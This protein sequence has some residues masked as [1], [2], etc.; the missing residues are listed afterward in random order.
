[1]TE[2]NPRLRL[3]VVGIIVMALFSALFVRLWFLQIASG[4]EAAA[5]ETTQNRVRIVRE[6][7]IRGRIL[8]AQ[9][10]VL[11]DNRVVNAITFDRSEILTDDEK[12]T[13]V[14]RVADVLGQTP[15]QIL[16]AIDD[17][18]QAAY[19]VVPIVEDPPIDVVTYIKEHQEEFY[20]VVSAQRITRRE[21]PY[22]TLGAHVLGYTAQISPEELEALKGQGY[23]SGDRIGKA[24]VEQ[25]FESELRGEPRVQRLEVDSRGNVVDIAEDRPAVPGKDVKL[26]IDLDIQR[27]AEESLAQGMDGARG[28]TCVVTSR[29]E[30]E[31]SAR[32][33]ASGGSVVV[34]DAQDGSVVAMA[35]AP[36]FNP[37]EL[38]A[39]DP[40]GTLENANEEES[41]FPLLNR[42]VQGTYAPGSTWKAISALAGLESGKLIRESTF[43]DDGCITIGDLDFCNAGEKGNGIVDLPR[44]I[45]VSS[46]V[47][48]YNLGF[49]LWKDYEAETANGGKVDL[50]YAIQ[51]TA[52]KFGFGAPTGIG[53]AGEARGRIP[54]QEFNEEINKRNPDL[55]ERSVNSQWKPG[56][57]A[58]LAVGQGD[59]L[60]TPLQL[61]NAYA[62]IANGG[63]KYTPRLASAILEPRTGNAEAPEE[64]VQEL[65]KQEIGAVELDPFHRAAVV[66]GLL[67]VVT[68]GEGTA[69]TAFDGLKDGTVAGKT[70]T[71]EQGANGKQDTSLFAG[72]SGVDPNAGPQYITVA[73]VEE[74]GFGAD[75]AAPIVR[76]VIDAIRGNAVADPVQVGE[77]S[78][79]D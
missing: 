63:T 76:R 22:G 17:P 9:G 11:V 49:G 15:E 57:S 12:Q 60:V 71:A 70:G 79:N 3:S 1:V 30:V 58:N 7:A 45:V 24:G 54:D 43:L 51:D 14:E 75:V 8:D 44:S 74:G 18:R 56:D 21:Y 40:F 32:C 26:T 29:D 37:A 77:G 68:S 52:R 6:P 64:V 53:L 25:M 66:D 5:Q 65:A 27:A 2:A 19:A 67:G 28:L 73:V 42:V 50:G 46:D 33:R 31:Q 36:S 35:S 10:R 78:A 48:Y 47:F 69:T 38:A 72:I 62:M 13:V 23:Q 16:E 34:L 55:N 59:L 4:T 39:G 61:A 41:S 20:D